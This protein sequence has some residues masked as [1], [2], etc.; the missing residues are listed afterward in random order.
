M[1]ACDGLALLASGA[2]FLE[3]FS[4]I[5]IREEIQQWMLSIEEEQGDFHSEILRYLVYVRFCALRFS[6]ASKGYQRVGS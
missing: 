3:G 5:S 2:Y 1:V 4:R 6:K